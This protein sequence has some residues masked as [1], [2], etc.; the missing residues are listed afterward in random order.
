MHYIEPRLPGTDPI[1]TVTF[2]TYLHADG[3][4]S[5]YEVEGRGPT[6][7]LVRFRAQGSMGSFD[8]DSAYV[9][10]LEYYQEVIRQGLDELR[11]DYRPLRWPPDDES[12]PQG[13][14]GRGRPQEPP[15]TSDGASE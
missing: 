1:A 11:G 4:V 15:L 12:G 6:G 8:H 5:H 13:P 7:A 9:R 10:S 2:T 3:F 14:T